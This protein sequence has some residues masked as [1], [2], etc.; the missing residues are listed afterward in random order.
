[1]K[2]L[3]G[4]CRVFSS[5]DGQI[6]TLANWTTRAVISR[7]SGADRITQTVHDYAP[8]ESPS[9]VNPIAEEALYVIAG[10]GECR[11]NGSAY[12]LRPGSAVFIPPGAVCSVKNHGPETLRIVSACCPEDPQRHI[13]KTV[14]PALPEAAVPEAPRLMVH[15]DDR[16]SIRAGKD[17]V[18][19]YLVYTDLG[20]RQIT[21]FA[22]WI[23]PGKAPFHYHTYEEGIHILEGRGIVHVVADESTGESCEFG[24]GDS[25]Y[26]PVGAR[27]CVENPGDA[28]IKLLGAFYPSGSPGAAY[29][30]S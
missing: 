18:F 19:R 17:R 25:I 23:P 15:E 12:P 1:M 7:N 29:E 5:E 9:V 24:P 21:Q 3:P 6:S 2:V 28:T 16:D 26:F 8:G 14:P 13:V 20:C 4:G 22:G 10:E 11:V 30:D 27:H